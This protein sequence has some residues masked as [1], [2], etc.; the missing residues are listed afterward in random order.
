M[1]GPAAVSARFWSVAGLGWVELGGYVGGMGSRTVVFGYGLL[2]CG[3]VRWW[4]GL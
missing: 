1:L 4:M 2:L 3:L